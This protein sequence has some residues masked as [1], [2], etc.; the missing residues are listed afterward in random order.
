VSHKQ[1]K[2]KNNYLSVGQLYLL[3]LQKTKGSVAKQTPFNVLTKIMTKVLKSLNSSHY[4]NTLET[5]LDFW[6][7]KT[8]EKQYY[9]GIRKQITLEKL[10]SIID[11]IPNLKARSKYWDTYH[12]SN[13]II[14]QGNIFR[15][16]LCR[17]RWCTECCRIKTAELTN[18]YKKPL[19]D[20]GQ[21][22][23]V[24]LTKP[25]VK[26]RELR[27]EIK[28]M[29]KAFQLI[30]NN[31]RN[32]Y[33]IK[34]QGMRKIEITYN[35]TTDTYHP[36]FHLIQDNAAAS[37]L[38]LELWL[39]QFPNAKS[40][41]QDIREIDTRN[42]NAFIELFKYATKETTK[43]GKTYSGF[44]LKT[45]YS[46]IEGLRIYQ[47]YG[48]IRKVKQ[49]D[50]KLIEE[51]TFTHIEEQDEIWV[52]NH[53][54]DWETASGQLLTNALELKGSIETKRLI[55]TKEHEPRRKQAYS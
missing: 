43:E 12:C 52:Y 14:Q 6:K 50:E 20:L 40:V 13:V 15:S 26:G 47:T 10:A 34:L 18:G 1:P 53:S 49:P 44:V 29:I 5:T 48:T 8:H 55:K 3:D 39:K 17:K 31:I 7:S 2:K 23:F 37:N 41:A 30:K 24:T 35:E 21:L 42:E 28:K 38:V 32:T 51:I 11:T 46:S 36:H 27:S 45:I 16:S 9:K 33:G 25:N 54:Y 22:Y 19:L 4:F